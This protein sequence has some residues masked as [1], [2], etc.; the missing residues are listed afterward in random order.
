LFAPPVV[1]DRTGSVARFVCQGCSFRDFG[2]R[3][4]TDPPTAVAGVA[5][6]T[7]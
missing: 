1:V 7:Y 2:M 5:R 3:S 6:S 4:T